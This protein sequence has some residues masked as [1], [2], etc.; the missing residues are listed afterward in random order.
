MDNDTIVNLE[1]ILKEKI[2]FLSKVTGE[3]LTSINVPII[4]LSL[5]TKEVPFKLEF[6][7]GDK[8]FI[9]IN[10]KLK[11][12]DDWKFWESENDLTIK[13]FDEK[14]Y[15]TANTSSNFLPSKILVDIPKS[16]II[17]EFTSHV[18]R[19]IGHM[20]VDSVQLYDYESLT[21]EDFKENKQFMT[22]IYRILMAAMKD[23]G[24]LLPPMLIKEPLVSEYM[25]EGKVEKLES[26]LLNSI[27][28]LGSEYDECAF[29]HMII[30]RERI[31]EHAKYRKNSLDPDIL[32][33][34][35]FK[36]IDKLIVPGDKYKDKINILVVEDFGSDFVLNE[37]GSV[38]YSDASINIL[39][40]K[41]CM[42]LTTK[43]KYDG[44]TIYSTINFHECIQLCEAGQI[45]FIM[46]DGRGSALLDA[47]RIIE[48]N[49][50]SLGISV[51][52]K[53]INSDSSDFIEE[54]QQLVNKI[55]SILEDKG[56]EKPPYVILPKNYMDIDLE[57]F[58][59]GIIPTTSKFSDLEEKYFQKHSSEIMEVYDLESK[60]ET[61]LKNTHSNI[62]ISEHLSQYTKS[63]KKIRLENDISRISEASEYLSELGNDVSQEEV[64][65]MLYS[66]LRQNIPFDLEHANSSTLVEGLHRI[67]LFKEKYSNKLSKTDMEEIYIEL[68][69][70]INTASV[71]LNDTSYFVNHSLS[72]DTLGNLISNTY[73]L[74]KKINEDYSTYFY[75]RNNSELNFVFKDFMSYSCSEDRCYED[76]VNDIMHSMLRIAKGLENRRA[77]ENKYCIT[78][79]IIENTKKIAELTSMS[80]NYDRYY[81]NLFSAKENSTETKETKS[82]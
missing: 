63:V 10:T 75:D 20:H 45:N 41:L 42:D 68:A 55:Y 38:I 60:F 36:E 50:I 65:T 33:S 16:K 73:I 56:L 2:D 49:D 58:V 15:H 74:L 23:E 5:L 61:A 69:Q 59:R 77:E 43:A 76:L 80:S 8:Y 26:M 32:L 4:D 51:N 79:F 39:A 30:E 37:A 71:P 28:S 1:N 6:S 21:V 62:S 18:E 12:L 64:S 3:K 72:F 66:M 34:D 7:L 13:K 40:K 57:S 11:Y 53:E 44:V 24:K 27:S 70:K 81:N 19:E 78:D 31:L 9:E 22:T 14:I 52:G 29:N 35:K 46:L 67:E 48:D 17:E 25:H 54:K 82:D 47:K